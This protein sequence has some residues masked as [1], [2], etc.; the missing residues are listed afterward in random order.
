[1]LWWMQERGYFLVGRW[2][3]TP[4]RVHWTAPIGALVFSGAK[5][6]PGAWLAFAIVVLAHE[7]GHAL[8][9]RVFRLRVTGID[10]HGAGGECRYAGN[11]TPV[12]RAVVAWGGVLG[13]LALLAVVAVL[14]ARFQPGREGFVADL[15]QAATAANVLLAL[16]NLLPVAPFDGREAWALVPALFGVTR[17]RVLSGR[18]RKLE[19]SIERLPP[20]V[21]TPIVRPE[22]RIVRTLIKKPEPPEEDEDEAELL[23]WAEEVLRKRKEPTDRSK[24]N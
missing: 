7:Q 9:A 8:L 14:A 20:R 12:Q 24:L 21:P 17:S 13:Q 19:R 4:V 23:R 15:V 6:A 2:L 1:M 11:P 5:L 16:F 3:G 22:V 10:L 18:V